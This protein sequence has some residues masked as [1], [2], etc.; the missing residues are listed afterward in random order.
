MLF[1]NAA[2]VL[3]DGDL[4]RIVSVAS[5]EAFGTP[6]LYRVGLVGADR[7]AV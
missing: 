1:A 5:A 7:N 6:Y 4:L 2:G 3:V